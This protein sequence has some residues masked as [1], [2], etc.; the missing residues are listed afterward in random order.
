MEDEIMLVKVTV[1]NFLSFEDETSFTMVSS[2]KI[3]KNNQH[4]VDINK[5]SILK[6]AVVYGANASGKSNLVEVFKFMKFVLANGIPLGVGNFFCKSSEDN[7]NKPSTIELQI[8]IDGKFYAYGF[9]FV[10]QERKFVAEWL[11]ELKKNGTAKILFEREAGK[12]I[13]IGIKNMS[14][15]GNAKMQIYK[16]DFDVVSNVLFLTFM[17]KDKSYEKTEELMFFKDVYDFIDKNI[18]VFKSNI[19]ITNF[20]YYYDNATLSKVNELIR[21]FDTGITDVNIEKVTLD[22]FKRELNEIDYENMMKSIHEKVAK[23]EKF[24][25]SLRSWDKFFNIKHNHMADDELEIT[26][27]KLKHGESFYN[28]NFGEESEGSRRLFD[29]LDMLLNKNTNQVYIVDELERSLHPKLT[30]KFI[31]LFNLI[32]KD[33]NVQ[34]IFTTHESSIMDQNLFRRDEVW[35]TERD[36]RNNSHIYSLDKFKERYDTKLSKAY[37]EGRYGAIPIFKTFNFEEE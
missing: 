25:I 31:E 12:D 8:E 30:Y 28:F 37:L 15:A 36:A 32:H 13:N 16:D 1:E 10:L 17:N 20:Q 29:L 27:I 3:Q 18:A 7:K 5:V 2:N 23:N 35:F 11:Y 34:L 24:N 4:K 26:T 19:P 6:N 9:S 21:I 33:K 22:E 14:S